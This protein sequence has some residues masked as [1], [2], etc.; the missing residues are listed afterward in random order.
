M[1]SKAG[2]ERRGRR[3]QRVQAQLRLGSPLQNPDLQM[4]WMQSEIRFLNKEQ[5]EKALRDYCC[6][7]SVAQLCLTLSNPMDCSM[8]GFPVHHQLLALA[9]THVHRLGDAIQPSHPLS[10]PSSPA[11]NLS[12]HRVFSK[13]SQAPFVSLSPR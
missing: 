9:Q 3:F 4:G 8:S 13:E 10:S 5:G 6:C 7:C 2:V 12:S 11:F 1:L